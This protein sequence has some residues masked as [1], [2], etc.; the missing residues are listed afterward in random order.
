MNSPFRKI[1][2]AIAFSPT[3]GAIL[4]EA[5]R[6][7][8]LFNAELVVIHVGARTVETES[9]I[10][11]LLQVAALEP[12]NVQLKWKS[13]DP[14]REVLKCCNEEHID[15]LVA[16]ALK[17]ENLVNHYIGTI[18]R[19]MLRKANCSLFI[20]CS[21]S[22]NPQSIQHIV[23]NAEDSPFIKEAI[24]AACDIGKLES[25]AWIHVVR[26]LKMLGLVLAANEQSNQQEYAES[27]QHLVQD[28]I[29]Q[30]EKILAAIPHEG[31]KINI[32]MLSGKSGF[33][34]AHFA[35]RKHADLLI[36]GAPSRRF[37]LFD[38]VFQ[39]DLEYI[40]ANMPCNLLMIQPKPASSNG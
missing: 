25:C 30:V 12:A 8:Q 10:N 17:K 16:G 27:K 37:S 31:L 35:E 14:V 40:F 28:E 18:G 39:H 4:R 29:D 9:K 23:V 13:G 34:L 33:E 6:L 11:D 19:K 21:P 3:A 38:R 15:L 26:E 32:K 1:G 22:M 5:A 36:V 20:I 7:Q 24:H 2:I